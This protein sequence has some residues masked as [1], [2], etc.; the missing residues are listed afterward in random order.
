[1]MNTFTNKTFYLAFPRKVDC[2]L[3]NRRLIIINGWR[4]ELY[5]RNINFNAKKL[6]DQ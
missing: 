3:V 1:M 6:C 2:L 4:D 5:L